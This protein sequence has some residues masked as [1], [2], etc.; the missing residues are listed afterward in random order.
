MN[1]VI[2]CIFLILSAKVNEIIN[3]KNVTSCSSTNALEV[4]QNISKYII[5]ELGILHVF[6]RQIGTKW[7]KWN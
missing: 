1:I 2:R 4:A 5:E 3:W 6:P 7:E